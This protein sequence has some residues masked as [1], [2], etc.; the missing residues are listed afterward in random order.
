MVHAT[1][2]LDVRLAGI[3]SPLGVSS[4]SRLGFPWDPTGSQIH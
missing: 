4:E 3:H 2:A 1:S